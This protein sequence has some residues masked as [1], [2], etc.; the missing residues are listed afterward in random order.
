MKKMP[1]EY[2]FPKDNLNQIQGGLTKREYFA[3]M[4]MQGSIAANYHSSPGSINTQ[5]AYDHARKAVMIADALI[6]ALN[7][8]ADHA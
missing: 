6:K 3:A 5:E 2:A 4:A 7:A 8:E 1:E